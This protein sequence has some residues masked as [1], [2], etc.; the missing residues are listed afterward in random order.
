MAVH[1]CIVCAML[2]ALSLNEAYISQMTAM[3]TNAQTGKSL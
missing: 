1:V 2:S 3:D